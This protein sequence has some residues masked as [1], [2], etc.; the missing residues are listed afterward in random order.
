MFVFIL[1]ID[2]FTALIEEVKASIDTFLLSIVQYFDIH[3]LFVSFLWRGEPII[4]HLVIILSLTFL[5][6]GLVFMYVLY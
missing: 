6:V 1:T 3:I 5:I 2:G 4:E